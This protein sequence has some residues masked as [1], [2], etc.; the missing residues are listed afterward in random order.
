MLKFW[1][2]WGADCRITRLLHL[3]GVSSYSSGHR[4]GRIL[5]WRLSARCSILQFQLGTVRLH[6]FLPSARL[7]SSQPC[8]LRWA[9]QLVAA[10]S[11]GSTLYI[12]A[13]WGV[14]CVGCAA[15]VR[16]NCSVH[17][18]TQGVSVWA[19]VKMLTVLH[20][21]VFEHVPRFLLFCTKYL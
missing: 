18:N 4:F 21:I 3:W 7:V 19:G 20:K 9:Q 2:F 11:C 14:G 1:V 12:C 6:Q 5:F 8:G 15:L 13:P 10:N 16:F 17:H